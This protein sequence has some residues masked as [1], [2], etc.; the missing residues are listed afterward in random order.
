MAAMVGESLTFFSFS[1]PHPPIHGTNRK[2]PR[3]PE[4]CF[5]EETMLKKTNL[6][7][8]F[9]MNRVRQVSSNY[10]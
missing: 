1:H 6:K 7:Y 8:V 5:Q 9:R 10:L 2:K 4:K 3:Q